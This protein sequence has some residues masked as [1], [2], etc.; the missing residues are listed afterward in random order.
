MRKFITGEQHPDEGGALLI[1]NTTYVGN[2]AQGSGGGAL[3][4]IAEVA[5]EIASRVDS[6]K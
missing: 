2:E 6:V 5:T 1:Q 4:A 3:F